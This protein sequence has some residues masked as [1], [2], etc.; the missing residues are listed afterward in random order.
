MRWPG[1]PRSLGRFAVLAD[2]AAKD[3]PALNPCG[4][5]DGLAVQPLR[6]ARLLVF[7][8]AGD[9]LDRCALVERYCPELT[10]RRFVG[11]EVLLAVEEYRAAYPGQA[12]LPGLR[13]R[14]EQVPW[15]FFQ[16]WSGRRGS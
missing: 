2:Q 12:E 15:P 4:D 9:Q 6:E 8:Q 5:I 16:E 11:A 7:G 3:M 14:R 1:V 10:E 13:G